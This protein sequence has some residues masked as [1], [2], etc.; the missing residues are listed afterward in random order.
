MQYAEY[1]NGIIE[2]KIACFTFDKPSHHLISFA[3]IPSSF[4]NNLHYSYQVFFLCQYQ[5]LIDL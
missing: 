3:F 2:T 5:Y 4:C 1:K